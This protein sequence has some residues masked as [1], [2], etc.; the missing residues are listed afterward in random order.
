MRNGRLNLTFRDVVGVLDVSQFPQ[1]RV[2]YDIEDNSQDKV[3]DKK[4]QIT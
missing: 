4:D 3:L 1:Y 2:S